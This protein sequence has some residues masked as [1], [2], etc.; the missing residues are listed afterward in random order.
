MD[1]QTSSTFSTDGFFNL[2]KGIGF[3][4]VGGVLGTA[5]M[6][7]I[8]HVRGRKLFEDPPP[9]KP[10]KGKKPDWLER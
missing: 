4:A 10:T 6:L 1:P 2:L 5:I 8:E 9:K 3:G 7:G